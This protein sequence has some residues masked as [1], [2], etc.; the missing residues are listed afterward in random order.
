MRRLPKHEVVVFLLRRWKTLLGGFLFR[1]SGENTVRKPPYH[2]FHP[3]LN[4]ILRFWLTHLILDVRKQGTPPSKYQSE[5]FYHIWCGIQHYLTWNGKLN[6]LSNP[7]FVDQVFTRCGYEAV[8]SQQKSRLNLSP[9]RMLSC[10]G[11]K[12]VRRC[13]TPV[14]TEHS[15]VNEWLVLC[16]TKWTT[17]ATSVWSPSYQGSGKWR[18]ALPQL[19]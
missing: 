4:K 19:H 10:C 11:G 17:S 2:S 3:Q 14:I 6:I 12:P 16:S 18:K 8:A 5:T 13:L 15:C 1:T 9:M 7:V